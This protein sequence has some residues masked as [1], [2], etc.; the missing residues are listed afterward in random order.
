MKVEAFAEVYMHPDIVGTRRLRVLD[1]GCKTYEGQ[2]SYADIFKRH[3]ADYVGLDVSPGDN[4]DIVPKDPFVWAELETESF[5]LCVSGQTFE[6]NPFFWITFSEIARVLKPGGRAMIVAPGR[7]EVHRFP[8]DCWRFYP[9]A[10]N[11]LCVY[12]GLI[13]EESH[14]EDYEFGHIAD[15]AEWCDSTVVARKP[16]LEGAQAAKFYK[17]LSKIIASLPE[18]SQQALAPNEPPLSCLATYKR[19]S[20]SSSFSAL[21]RRLRPFGVRRRVLKAL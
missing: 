1:I 11:A 3:N 17:N 14:F 21:R 9:D 8:V 2:R 18:N 16:V 4:V 10:W 7:G 15:G 12:T 19:R 20:H 5:D 13:L 6:H